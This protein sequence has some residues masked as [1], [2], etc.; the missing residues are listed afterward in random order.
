MTNTLSGQNYE[1]TLD[2]VPDRAGLWTVT[3]YN[4]KE[5]FSP[6]R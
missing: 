3:L 6:I 5:Q 4:N 1:I 2:F